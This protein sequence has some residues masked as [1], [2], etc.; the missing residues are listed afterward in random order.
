VKLKSTLTLLVL[1]G[2][3]AS[4][5]ATTFSNVTLVPTGYTLR[6]ITYATADGSTV[7]VDDV[8]SFTIAPTTLLAISK[9]FNYAP[10][11]FDLVGGNFSLYSGTYGSGTL[12]NAATP[13]TTA[14]TTSDDAPFAEFDSLSG[15][16][17]YVEV[18]GTA[19]AG[20]SDYGVT[21]Y[22]GTSPAVSAVPEPA[23]AALLL[24][25]LGL[26]GFMA[27]RRKQS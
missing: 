25:G 12:V 18:T 15:G 27:K 10:G 11:D 24:A 6:G 26:M 19:A 14:I 1:A 20:G 9:D 17:Y 2:L 21:L 4:A 13:G 5:S 3:G 23:N 22:G 16:N 7:A 8:Y